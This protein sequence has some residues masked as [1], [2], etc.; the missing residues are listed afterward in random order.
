MARA[1]KNLMDNDLADYLLDNYGICA[2]TP[3]ACLRSG[4]I[5]RQCQNW[6]PNGAR[7]WEDLRQVQ[8]KVA[9]GAGFEPAK[10]LGL[11]R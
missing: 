7:T 8:R 3:C 5:G 11:L 9:G 4:W 1:R 2:L 6:L 10:P